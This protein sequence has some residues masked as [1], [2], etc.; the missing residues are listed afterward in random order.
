MSLRA[1]TNSGAVKCLFA[2]LPLAYGKKWTQLVQSESCYNLS[3]TSG[4][5][6]SGCFAMKTG[7][8]MCCVRQSNFDALYLLCWLSADRRIGLGF[9]HCGGMT[10]ASHFV[11]RTCVHSQNMS[12]IWTDAHLQH[13]VLRWHSLSSLHCCSVL[14]VLL[15]DCLM[16]S[17]WLLGLWKLHQ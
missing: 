2:R 3:P 8:S 4:V 1:Y 10:L 7:M 6:C 16:S 11:L 9:I 14:G 17:K 13:H 5:H 15:C 12:R